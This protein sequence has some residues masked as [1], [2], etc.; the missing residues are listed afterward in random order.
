[1][2]EEGTGG[3]T[4]GAFRQSKLPISGR[5]GGMWGLEIGGKPGKKMTNKIGEKSFQSVLRDN[6]LGGVRKKKELSCPIH[7]IKGIH[8]GVL[9]GEFLFGGWG[10][11]A[12][13]RGGTPID[14]LLVGMVR[15]GKREQ[16][17]LG[18]KKYRGNEKRPCREKKG[19]LAP[20]ER[21]LSKKF[22]MRRLET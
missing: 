16:G 21:T 9:G 4:G 7:T 11:K 18:G 20:E 10:T 3:R 17:E 22:E 5:L 1:V 8:R 12:G 14:L 19:F 15:V 6:T 2:R 13:E